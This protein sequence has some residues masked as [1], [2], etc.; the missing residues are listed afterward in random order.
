M[1]IQQADWASLKE[2]TQGQEEMIRRMNGQDRMAWLGSLTK[3]A[4]HQVVYA[5]NS[6]PALERDDN[7][8]GGGWVY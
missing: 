6:I 2:T 3:G 5:I 1:S 7:I 8:G 4:R